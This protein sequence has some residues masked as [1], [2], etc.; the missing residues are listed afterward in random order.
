MP[1]DES[2]HTTLLLDDGTQINFRSIQPTDE[3]SMR[4]LVYDL[5]RETIYYRFMSRESSF[6]HKQ[7]QNFVYVDHRKDVAI[8]GTVPEAHGENIIAVGRYFLDEQTNRAEVAFVVRDDWQNRGIGSFLFLHLADL[9]QGNGI[10][11]FTAEILRDNQRMQTIFNH[12]SYQTTIRLE[13]GVYSF[14]VDF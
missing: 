7:I 11:G 2:M 1:S 14:V 5:S 6:T 12:S 9:A 8:V 10:F 4:D 13:R 3:P